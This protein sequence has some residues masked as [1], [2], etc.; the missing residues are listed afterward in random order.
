M[1]FEIIACF[2]M[3][4]GFLVSSQC[5]AIQSKITVDSVP[6]LNFHGTKETLEKIKQI[7]ANQQKGAYMRFGDGDTILAYGQHDLMQ[8]PNV[9]LEQEMRETFGLNHKNILKALPLHTKELGTNES[10]MFPGN[11]E[12]NLEQCINLL[13]RVKPLWGCE[14]TDVYSPVALHH[15]A[16][17]DIHYCVDFLKFIRGSNCVLFIGNENVPDNIKTL[18]WGPQCKHIK[19]P[20]KNAYSSIDRIERECY[21][22]ICSDSTYKVIIIA[23]G[24]SGRVLAKRLWQNLGNVFFFDFGSLLDALCGWNTRAWIELTNFDHKEFIA[25]IAMSI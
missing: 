16:V 9:R 4:I 8:D 18:L 13:K 2:G 12:G 11:H 7:I 6:R 15:V 19:T 25:K 22:N 1:K 17:A 20:S 24:C 14:I 5:L 10:G 3:F 21:A 23:M